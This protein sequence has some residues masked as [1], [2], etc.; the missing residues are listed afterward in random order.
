MEGDELVMHLGV[1]QRIDREFAP[2]RVFG[3][4]ALRIG[5]WMSRLNE[6]AGRLRIADG[7]MRRDHDKTF[8]GEK[9]K[10]IELD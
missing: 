4:S 10:N 5:P 2:W 9:A 3:V 1:S 7:Q 8:Y 6:I